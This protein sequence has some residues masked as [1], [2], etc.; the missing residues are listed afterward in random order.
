MGLFGAGSFGTGVLAVFVTENGTGTGV[1]L[2]FGGVLLV[3]ALLG[4]RIES[5]EFGGAKLK[6][7]AAAAERFALAEESERRGDTDTANRLRTEA[8]ALLDAAGPIAAD[9]RSV[10]GSMRAGPERTRAMTEVV[11]RARRISAEQSFEPAEVVRWLREGSDEERITALAMMQ[12]RQELRNFDAALAAIE[13]SRSAFEQYHAMVLTEGM[14]G[15]LDPAQLRRLA[16]VI[17]SQRG[18]RFRSDSDRWQLSEQ[19]LR[20]VDRAAPDAR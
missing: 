15:D 3:L 6:L 2:I 16:E 13:D 17:R 12:A 4:D 18:W 11:A 8:Q 14:I 5:L 20:R 10:R 7:R 9:Y 1:L 19:I